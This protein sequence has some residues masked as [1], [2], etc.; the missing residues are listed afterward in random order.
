[1]ALSGIHKKKVGILGTVGEGRYLGTC[2]NAS[3]IVV[4]IAGLG[5]TWESWHVGSRVCE[6]D[7]KKYRR[8]GCG[9]KRGDNGVGDIVVIGDVKVI[10][11]CSITFP[12]LKGQVAK[13]LPAAMGLVFAAGVAR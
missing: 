2:E 13:L 10:I 8:L 1:V 6:T 3:L 12:V 11:V 7:T 5:G 9:V 4:A